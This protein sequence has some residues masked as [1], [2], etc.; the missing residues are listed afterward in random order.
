MDLAKQLNKHKASI[1]RAF[2]DLTKD[3]LIE[4]LSPNSNNYRFY[5]TTEKGKKI[6]QELK[7]LK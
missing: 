5:K 3:G 4:C 2:L 7:T 1:S 6:L